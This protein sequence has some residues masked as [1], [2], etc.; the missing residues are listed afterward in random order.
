MGVSRRDD[1]KTH[2]PVQ[3]MT[4]LV[5]SRKVQEPSLLW[6]IVDQGMLSAVPGRLAQ[7]EPVAPAVYRMA[8]SS[9]RLCS[10]HPAGSGGH[11]SGNAFSS[12]LCDRREFPRARLS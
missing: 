8:P 9:S 10:E 2:N 7:C 5:S 4:F 11:K 1:E 3:Y 6:G 12:T